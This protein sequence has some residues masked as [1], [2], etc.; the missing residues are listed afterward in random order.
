MIETP[1]EPRRGE[2]VKQWD[3]RRRE[4]K[5]KKKKKTIEK[6]GGPCEEERT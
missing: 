4:K 6:R 3:K 1:D 2:E 5:D